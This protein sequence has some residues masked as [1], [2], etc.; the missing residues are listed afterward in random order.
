MGRETW[1]FWL[2]G[3]IDKATPYSFQDLLATR[4]QGG[5]K[6]IK[7]QG[8]KEFYVQG[9]WACLWGF[10]EETGQENKVEHLR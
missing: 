8:K 5:S 6:H 10:G 7:G 3:G 1:L 4:K 9:I 2:K